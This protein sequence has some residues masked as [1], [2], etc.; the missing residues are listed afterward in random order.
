MDFTKSHSYLK[1]RKGSGFTLIELLI[2][3]AIILILI[4]IAL[5]NFLEAQLRARVVRSKGEIRSL[6]TAM[7]S[8]FLDW[9]VYPSESEQ[10]ALV[11]GARP[12]DQAGLTWL[13]SPV[14]YISALPEDPF[15]GA[16]EAGAQALNPAAAKEMARMA[17]REEGTAVVSLGRPQMMSMVAAMSPS[18]R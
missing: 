16:Q 9:K 13:T 15:P 11:R 17:T 3:I 7:E 6:I 14:V 4:A 10:D 8:Y 2:V 1:R 12:R 5:P 18:M